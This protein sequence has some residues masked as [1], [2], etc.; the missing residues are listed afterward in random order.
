MHI[1]DDPVLLPEVEEGRCHGSGRTSALCKHCRRRV[2]WRLMD[3]GGLFRGGSQVREGMAR[4]ASGT[5]RTKAAAACLC[6]DGLPKVPDS[7]M[8]LSLAPWVE[9]R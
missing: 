4:V 9:V 3:R 2:Q 8:S 1:T 7:S 5:G 6:V